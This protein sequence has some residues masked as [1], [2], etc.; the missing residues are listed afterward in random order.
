VSDLYSWQPGERYRMHGSMTP[1][2]HVVYV[3]DT[4]KNVEALKAFLA[5]LEAFTPAAPT[6][7]PFRN[8]G[9]GCCAVCEDPPG[10]GVH[11]QTGVAQA[12]AQP[13]GEGPEPT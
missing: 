3:P 7:H 8:D 2:G 5:G 6:T 10:V 9:S 11:A 4:P 1:P 13:W 12:Y